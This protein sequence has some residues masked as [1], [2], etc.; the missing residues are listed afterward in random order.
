MKTEPE[1]LAPVINWLT[2]HPREAEIIQWL[3]V[4]EAPLE[5]LEEEVQIDRG[6]RYFDA[7]KLGVCQECWEQTVA[8]PDGRS[9]LWPSLHEHPCEPLEK[10]SIPAKKQEQRQVR[11]I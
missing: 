2:L 10:R 6:R 1:E 3:A 5:S 4:N 9:I 11:T 7:T 8:F